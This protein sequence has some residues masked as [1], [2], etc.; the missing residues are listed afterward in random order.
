M[1][2]SYRIHQIKAFLLSINN[3]VASLGVLFAFFKKNSQEQD[4]NKNNVAKS[5]IWFVLTILHL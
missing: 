2:K 1:S 3:N 4:L 5:T